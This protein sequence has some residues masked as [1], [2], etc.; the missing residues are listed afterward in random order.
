MAKLTKKIKEIDVQIKSKTAE[1]REAEVSMYYTVFS[2]EEKRKEDIKDVKAELRDLL[3][4]K[5]ATIESLQREFEFVKAA[6]SNQQRYLTLQV[7][8]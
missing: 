1:L 2:C 3:S 5:Y 8:S 4:L 7:N 6:I